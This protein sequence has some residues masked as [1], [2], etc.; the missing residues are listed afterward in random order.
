MLEASARC[1]SIAFIYASHHRKAQERLPVSNQRSGV[2]RWGRCI[3]LDAGKLQR[4][5]A[6]H[7]TS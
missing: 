3:G 1:L 7:L 2:L 5:A 4:P 6:A